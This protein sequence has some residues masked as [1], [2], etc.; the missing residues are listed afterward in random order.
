MPSI[1]DAIFGTTPAAQLLLS[2]LNKD[3]YNAIMPY[4]YEKFRMPCY[5]AGGRYEETVL[6]GLDAGAGMARRRKRK[7]G[8]M[9]LG[10]GKNNRKRHMLDHTRCIVTSVHESG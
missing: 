8:E 2:K 6:C 5:E 10:V 3:M 7:A 4:I 1:R 9:D